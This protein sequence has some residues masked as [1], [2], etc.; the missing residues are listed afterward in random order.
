MRKSISYLLIAFVAYSCGCNDDS[1]ESFELNEFERTIIP[2][3]TEQNLEYINQSSQLFDAILSEKTIDN[4]NLNSSD[5]ESCAVTLVETH[6]VEFTLTA[7]NQE[8]LI[9]V[10][11]SRTDTQ[12]NIV[13]DSR[14]FAINNCTST[15]EI[16][17]PP[18]TDFSSDG[19]DFEN[20]YIFD[21]CGSESLIS[22]IIYSSVN[23][24]EFI[25]LE[26]GDYLK[27]VE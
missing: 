19:F 10:E 5:D 17:E 7:T 25:K 26:N 20:V 1:F 11:K 21:N 9:L 3:T 27:L 15:F 13:T 16:I 8:F 23:G 4:F 24:V 6:R 14:F 12:F 22:K 2:F 18:T